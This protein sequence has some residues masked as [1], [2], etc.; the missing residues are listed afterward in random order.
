MRMSFLLNKS[1]KSVTPESQMGASF[2]INRANLLHLSGSSGIL[3]PVDFARDQRRNKKEGTARGEREKDILGY[4]YK[5][6]R[7]KQ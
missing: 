2:R 4:S 6:E 7:A 3:P 5:E 1:L